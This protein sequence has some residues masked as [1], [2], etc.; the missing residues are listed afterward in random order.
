[1]AKDGT[2]RWWLPAVNRVMLAAQRLGAP[3]TVLTLTGRRSGRQRRTPVTPMD[4]DGVRYLVAGYPRAQWVHNARAAGEG[5]LSTGRRHT[6]VRLVELP[7]E[8]ARPVLREFPVRV[9]TAVGPMVGAGTVPDPSPEAFAALA[10]RC[11]VFRVEE[12]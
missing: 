4:R 12:A 9:P 6:R 10:G 3:V 2:P 11:A 8:E 1:M 5:T 7:P